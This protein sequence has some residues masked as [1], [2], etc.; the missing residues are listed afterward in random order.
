[1]QENSCQKRLTDI[2]VVLS[3]NCISSLNMNT[4]YLLLGSN[5]GE[6]ESWLSKAIELL[7]SEAGQLTARSSLYNTAPWLGTNAQD[8]HAEPQQDFL[9]Q[10]VELRTLLS[11]PELLRKMLVIEEKLGR[12][13]DKKWGPR[14]IDIDILFFNQDEINTAELT[15]PHP[16]L[17]ERRFTLL[18]LAEIAEDLVH[19]RLKKSVKKLLSECSD[20]LPVTVHRPA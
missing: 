1:M 6:R 16:F 19:P 2:K 5:L 15:I 7:K 4:A 17:H 18:P 20:K 11:S 14:T 12:K 8:S 3:Y 10:A 9:N 13:R